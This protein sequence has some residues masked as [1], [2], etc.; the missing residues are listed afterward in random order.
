MSA[1]KKSLRKQ[2]SRNGLVTAFALAALMGLGIGSAQAQTTLS[3]GDIGITGCISNTPD[4]FTFVVDRAMDAGT[5]IKFTDNAFLSSGSATAASNGRGGE[6]FV[7]WTAP[8]GGT[9]TLDFGAAN[10]N[11][12]V[13][14]FGCFGASPMGS[15]SITDDDLGLD[16]IL[17]SGDATSFRGGANVSFAGFGTAQENQIVFERCPY[18]E[19]V[20][21]PESTTI[22]GALGLLGAVCFRERPRLSIA[23]SRLASPTGA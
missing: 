10:A 15:L 13:V 18:Y 2:P 17:I 7:T 4:G 1:S 12:N 19:L 22:L 20:P 21:V 14:R 3:A 11:L 23:L 6:N 8:A 16:R 9:A 5:A